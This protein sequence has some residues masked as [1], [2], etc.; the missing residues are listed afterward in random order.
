MTKHLFLLF[1]SIVSRGL[2]GVRPANATL[3][4]ILN[5]LY[6]TLLADADIVDVVMVKHENIPGN[7]TPAFILAVALHFAHITT[8]TVCK[9]IGRYNYSH[10]ITAHRIS[11]PPISNDEDVNARIQSH[12]MLPTQGGTGP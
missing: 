6:P 7:H 8:C 11:I 3:V 4:E 12:L 9:R 1:C 2:L 10:P 5:T